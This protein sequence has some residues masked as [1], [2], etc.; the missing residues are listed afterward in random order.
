MEEAY[1][2]VAA[3]YRRAITRP[4]D[5]RTIEEERLP[6]YKSIREFQEDL[7]LTFTNCIEFNGAD[8]ELGQLSL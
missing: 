3:E 1:P 6:R 5:F 4:M 2:E 7:V 8:S